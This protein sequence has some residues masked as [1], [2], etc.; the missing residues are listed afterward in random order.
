MESLIVLVLSTLIVMSSAWFQHVL[1]RQVIAGLEGLTGGRVEIGHFRFRPWLF[2]IRLDKLVI[3]GA[4]APGDPPLMTAREVE[5]GISPQQLLRRRLRLRHLD[6]DALEIHFRT[7]SQGITN[8]PGPPER[9]SPQRRLTDLMDLSIGRLTVSHSAFFWN[10][11]RQPVDINAKDLA[12]LL[13]MSRG[14]YSGTLSSSGATIRSKSWSS[15][16]ITFNSRFELST[17][18]SSCLLICMAS[19]RDKRRGRVYDP[20]PP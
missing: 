16:P 8:F 11:Q 3:H 20:S 17:R 9:T 6:I 2:Q 1:E 19:T 4:E 7:S 10:D 14:R 5:A 12:I 15:P 18:Q 13:S